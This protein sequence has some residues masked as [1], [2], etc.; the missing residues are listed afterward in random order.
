MLHRYLVLPASLLVLVAFALVAT[1]DPL[2]DARRDLY[3]GEW[4]RDVAIGDLNGDD[5]LD[6]VVPLHDDEDVAV[7]L[8]YGNGN[9]EPAVTYGTAEWSSD[10][11]NPFSAAVGKLDGDDH[12]DV[13]VANWGSHNI[14]ILLGM[15]DGTLAESDTML[16]GVNPNC[17]ILADLNEDTRP[18][19]RHGQLERGQHNVLIGDGAGYFTYAPV[20][21]YGVGNGPYTVA[22]GDFDED[23][24]IDLVV[25]NM[26]DDNFSVLIGNGDG[27][28]NAAVNYPAGDAPA[29]RLHHRLQ[30]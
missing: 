28:F 23:D 11:E 8:G 2:F 20:P 5:H 14:G 17:V 6:L 4:P 25:V 29:R 3:C 10:G 27:S 22:A 7:L 13:V 21:Q 12:E 1:A 15:G 16:A 24:D 19:R 18:R 26:W 9:F 30:P